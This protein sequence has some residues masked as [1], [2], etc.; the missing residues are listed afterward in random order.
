MQHCNIY[1]GCNSI[2]FV[3]GRMCLLYSN[4]VIFLQQRVNSL[5]RGK[6]EFGFN[7]SIYFGVILILLT[8]DYSALGCNSF[9]HNQS[10][11]LKNILTNFNFT[12]SH[13]DRKCIITE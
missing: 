3:V 8:E 11:M 1:T 4:L 7:T 5:S 12:C 2:Q 10:N 6:F 13:G 9:S